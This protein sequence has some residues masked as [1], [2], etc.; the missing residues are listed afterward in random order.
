MTCL[1]A[2]NVF[3]FYGLSY[4][5]TSQ[6]ALESG[7]GSRVSDLDRLVLKAERLE[8][9]QHR[10]VL[11]ARGELIRLSE[12]RRVM[13]RMVAFLQVRLHIGVVSVVIQYN[14]V[15]YCDTCYMQVR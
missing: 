14:C 2:N 9:G 8:M 10:A 5:D 3:S 7:S 12:K 13:M 6:A 4:S 1:F 15:Y 11:K